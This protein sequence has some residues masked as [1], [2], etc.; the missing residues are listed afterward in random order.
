MEQSSSERVEN[1]PRVFL[2]YGSEDR[3]I[4]EQLSDQLSLEGCDALWDEVTFKAGAPLSSEIAWTIEQADACVLIVG[5]RGLRD[6][7]IEEAGIMSYNYT[8]HGK[9]VM[10]YLLDGASHGMVPIALRHRISKSWP[11]MERVAKDVSSEARDARRGICAYHV[12]VDQRPS[13]VGIRKEITLIWLS[14][15]ALFNFQ[16]VLQIIL[17]VSGVTFLS[18]DQGALRGAASVFVVAIGSFMHLYLSCSLLR[19][20]ISGSHIMLRS[21][22]V[23]SFVGISALIFSLLDNKL[24]EY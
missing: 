4:V 16:W 6:W 9:P 8:K 19:C 12:R 17:L 21:S 2:S 11:G 14:H 22:M 13:Y 18:L 7:Q 23:M 15:F 1:R 5:S 24:W 20:K 3:N 10:I